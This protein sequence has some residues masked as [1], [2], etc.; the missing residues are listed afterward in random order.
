MG[1]PPIPP[2]A[3]PVA[4][5]PVD[6]LGALPNLEADLDRKAAALKA[7]DARLLREAR[8]A[9]REE[10]GGTPAPISRTYVTGSGKVI[11]GKQ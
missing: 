3:P 4:T 1:R 7:A 5:R 6:P 11:G 10:R 2:P 8:E 9:F